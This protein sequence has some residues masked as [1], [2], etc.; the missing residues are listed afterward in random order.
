MKVFGDVMKITYTTIDDISFEEI[1]EHLSFLPAERQEKIRRFRFEKDKLLS[2]AAGMLILSETGDSP[3]TYGEHG[4]PYCCGVH[5]SVSHSGTIAAIAVDAYEVGVD[6]EVIPSE[7]RLKIAERFYH[8]AECAYVRGADDQPLAFCEIWTRKE[9]Y[10]K[11]TGEGISA[12][13][14]AFDSA[15]PPLS[16]Q[17]YTL[18]LGSYC[19][20]VCSAKQIDADKIQIANKELK[21]LLP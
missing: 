2:F 7:D 5:F 3:L 6:T 12:D 15:S 8:P 10:L 17:L 9:A 11:M 21:S 16:R 14:T 20:S 18:R 13:L 1:K 4:K 19:L